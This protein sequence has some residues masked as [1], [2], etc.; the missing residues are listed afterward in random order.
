MSGTTSRRLAGIASMHIDGV[1][2]DV[3]SDLV[4]NCN[5][6]TRETLKGQTAVEGY[7]EMP[8]QGF[9]GATLRDRGDATVADF[10]RMTNATVICRLANGKQVYGS[11]MWCVEAA[12]VRTHEASF[13]V[14]FEGDN[15]TEA[16]I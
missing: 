7:S 6:V 16:P 9:I 12:E 3:V 1:P 15:V 13:A 8:T 14:R 4:Y 10:N 5:T 11:G 2:W